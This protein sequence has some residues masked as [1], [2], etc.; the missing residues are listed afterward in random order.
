[1]LPINHQAIPSIPLDIRN[2]LVK[3]LTPW[4]VSKRLFDGLQSP[5][6]GAKYKKVQV[7]PDNKEWRFIWRYFHFMG[8]Q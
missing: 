6:P 8:S 3:P 2:E 5:A 7:L 4:E 1:M